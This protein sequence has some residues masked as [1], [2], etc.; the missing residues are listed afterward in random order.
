[1]R[2]VAVLIID[3]PEADSVFN[4]PTAIVVSLDDDGRPSIRLRSE[5]ATQ[6][7]EELRERLDGALI[8]VEVERP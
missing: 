3:T 2:D 4:G 7:R 8:S 1:M 6:R 5:H